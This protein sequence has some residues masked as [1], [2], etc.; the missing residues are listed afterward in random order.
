MN[1]ASKPGRWELNCPIS[2]AEKS[3]SRQTGLPPQPFRDCESAPQ[4]EIL[5]RS[6]GDDR[7]SGNGPHNPTPGMKT[8]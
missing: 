6:S 8:S 4:D 3:H 5:S 7:L 2:A 1:C